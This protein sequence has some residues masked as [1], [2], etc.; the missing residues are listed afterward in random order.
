MLP[1]TLGSD[2]EMELQLA[3]ELPA[4]LVDES[5]FEAMLLNLA[6]NSRDAMTE[7]GTFSIRTGKVDS[8]AVKEVL[9]NTRIQN[10]AFVHIAVSDTGEGMSDEAL[11]K[12]FEPFFTTKEK[13][14]GTGLGLAMIYGFVKQSRGFVVLASEKGV[15]TTVHI[16]LPVMDED[17][18]VEGEGNQS[19]DTEGFSGEGRVILLVDDETELLKIAEAYL[20]DLGFEVHCATCGKEALELMDE[21]EQIDLLLTDVVMPGGING[22]ALAREV[23]DRDAGVAVLYASGFPTGVIEENSKVV[24]DAPLLHKPYSLKALS[25]AMRDV[26]GQSKNKN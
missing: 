23:T 2:I 13:D 9:P 7:G 21:L 18:G 16:Y 20:K 22:V 15:G 19:D 25:R 8:L 5:G 1:Q 17:E 14:K 11:E 24:L 4:I 3:P 6:I 12:A 26:L 10:G